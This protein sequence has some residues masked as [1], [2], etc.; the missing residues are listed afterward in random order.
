MSHSEFEKKEKLKKGIMKICFVSEAALSVAAGVYGWMNPGA[1][2]LGAAM[3][4]PIINL[5]RDTTEMW[6]VQRDLEDEYFSAIEDALENTRMKFLNKPSKLNLLNELS[7]CVTEM[8]M[9]LES[10]IQNTETFQLQYMTMIDVR[11][12]L[13]I[14]ESAF[15]QEIAKHEKLSRY[16]TIRTEK[17][18]LDLLKRVHVIVTADSVKL[19]KIFEYVKETSKNTTEIKAEVHQIKDDIVFLKNI[20]KWMQNA[21]R[22]TAEILLQ[23]MVI[24]FAFVFATV[25][26]DVKF[27]DTFTVYVVV[28]VSEVLVHF[29]FVRINGFRT[30]CVIIMTQTWFISAC[31]MLVLNISAEAFIYIACCALIGVS[32]KFTLLFIQSS[33]IKK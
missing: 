9:D 22:F 6:D 14:F 24:Y 18:T 32:A 17:N 31:S 20:G 3:A 21:L 23:S 12:I 2:L 27:W 19:D 7:D 16:Y 26:L 4:T 30:A 33:Y 11:E 15:D 1:T 28:L 10:I 29:L 8:D 5:V 25:L 13:V